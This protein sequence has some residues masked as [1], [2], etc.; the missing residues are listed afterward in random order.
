MKRKCLAIVLAAGNGHRMNSS[1]SKVL[2]QIAGKPMI[3]YVMEAIAKA[4]ISDVALVVGHLAEFV[5]QID[6]PPELSIEYYNQDAQQGTAHAVLSARN[7]IKRGYDN[8]IVMYADVPLISSNTLNKAIDAMKTECSVAVIGFKTNQPNGYGRL[9]MENNK[10]I[11][12]REEK[13]ATDQEKKVNY[14]N[15]GLMVIDGH[16]ILDWL[17]KINKNDKTKE[18]YLTNI[19][20]IARSDGKLISSIEVQEQEVYGCNN[21]HELSIIENTWQYSFRHKMMLSG[22]TMIAPE[23]VFFSHDTFIDKDTI[24]EPHVI[25]GCGVT[26]E[27]FVKIK[28][29]SYLEGVYIS[30]NTTIGPFARL[31]KGSKIEQNVKIGNFCEIKNSS[32]GEGSKINHLSYVGD[33][34]LGKSVNIGAGSITCNYDGIN[35]YE[36]HISDNV[37]VGSNS[38]LI[39]PI[40]I[41]KNSYIASGSVV[42][43]DAPEDSLVLARSRQVIKKNRS[44]SMKKKK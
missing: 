30:N 27:S 37:F 22:V 25:F 2:H 23:T 36:T 17:L 29:F 12:I 16:H 41:G 1:T 15:S 20:E 9:L 8:I 24:I 33:S 18:Y 21:R 13:D 44:L 38:S 7:A 3:S 11:A 32:I 19:I 40:F 39:A 6:F 14:C 10:L 31:R 5:K 43:E 35:K 4:G 34:F 42:T 26:V 28:S